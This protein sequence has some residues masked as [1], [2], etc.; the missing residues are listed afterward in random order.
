MSPPPRRITLETHRHRH[1]ESV[2]MNRVTKP[3]HR[4]PFLTSL[5]LTTFLAIGAAAGIRAHKSEWHDTA[6]IVRSLVAIYTVLLT[7]IFMKLN[8]VTIKL[9]VEKLLD[10]EREMEQHDIVAFQPPSVSVI[11]TLLAPMK[12]FVRVDA[13]GLDNIPSNTSH[14]FVMNHSLY[15]IEMPFLIQT[16]Y[17]QKGI[18]VRG[19]A[20]NLHFATPNE[21][22]LK[23]F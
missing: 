4:I 18:F 6:M 23:Q 9:G 19:L 21:L 7:S 13:T 15:G 5:L 8:N 1:N 12:S 10:V 20:D 17:K 16:L 14:L 22:L 2:T 3:V 11:D